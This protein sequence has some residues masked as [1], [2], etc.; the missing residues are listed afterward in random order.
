MSTRA[1]VVYS[2]SAVGAPA[3]ERD[4]KILIAHE[5]SPA[6]RVLAK[7]LEQHGLATATATS[8]AEVLRQMERAEAFDVLLL[9]VA[10]PEPA[11][12]DVLVLLRERGDRTPIILLAAEASTS[13][14]V[15]GLALG[16]D[17]FVL[18]PFELVELL[19]RMEA[20]QRRAEPSEVL[21]AGGLVLDSQRRTLECRGVRI[22]LSPLEFDFLRAIVRA[23]GRTLTRVEL[24]RQVWHTEQ[25]PDSNVVNVTVARVR[26]RLAPWSPGLIRTVN[27]GYRL[28]ADALAG[29]DPV[30]P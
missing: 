12:L 14:R 3:D 7:E 16:A 23:R 4:V 17:D 28:A 29:T 25:V 1:P 26:R 15:R 18:E 10:L 21:H 27:G 6:L 20:V 30:P 8:G 24:L 9:D 22:E 13:E 11:G 5:S 2:S 19:A